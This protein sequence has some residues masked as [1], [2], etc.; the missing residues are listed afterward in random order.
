MIL[1]KPKNIF[2]ANFFFFFYR[3]EQ[4]SDARNEKLFCLQLI[5]KKLKIKKKEENFY[6]KDLRILIRIFFWSWK[7]NDF[8]SKP[9][10]SYSFYLW[11]KLVNRF[12][13][14]NASFNF[15]SF[16]SFN[17]N[18]LSYKTLFRLESFQWSC[19]VGIKKMQKWSN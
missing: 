5:E 7:K 2:G 16:D 15:Q 17:D 9:E 8:E 4:K 19:L 3:S 11:T 14:E 18:N 10:V 13:Q 1:G 12:L 6:L